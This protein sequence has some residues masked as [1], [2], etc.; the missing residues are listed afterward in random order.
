MTAGGWSNVFGRCFSAADDSFCGDYATLRPAAA[1]GAR[2]AIGGEIGK[3]A[4]M[5]PRPDGQ[6]GK[7]RRAAGTPIGK[8]ARAAAFGISVWR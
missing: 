7:R 6:T 4:A 8:A 5:T 1:T 3:S 2:V